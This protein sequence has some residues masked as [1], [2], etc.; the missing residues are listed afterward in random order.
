MSISHGDKLNSILSY[1]Y[2]KFLKSYTFMYTSSSE[3]LVQPSSYK[4]LGED[5]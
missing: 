4:Q 1:L 5:N 2:N 3:L